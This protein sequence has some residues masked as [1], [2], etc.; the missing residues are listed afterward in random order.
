MKFTRYGKF[1]GL[2]VS[3]INLGD[4]MEALQ[5]SLLQSGYDDDYYWS[6]RRRQP[7]TSLDALRAAL[8][9]ALVEQGLLS[10]YQ[11]RVLAENDGKFKV[12]V[13]RDAQSVD[14]AAG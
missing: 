10:E 2:D 11:V 5:D 3:G 8:L 14:R 4:L 7:Y 13:G 12:R 1:N 9:E 6:R